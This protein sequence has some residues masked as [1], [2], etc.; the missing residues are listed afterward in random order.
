MRLSQSRKRKKKFPCGH[1]GFGKECHLCKDLKNG[2]LI[3]IEDVLISPNDPRVEV[4]VRERRKR[5]NSIITGELHLRKK[6]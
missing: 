6:I 5:G 1:K 4:E 3:E 2:K